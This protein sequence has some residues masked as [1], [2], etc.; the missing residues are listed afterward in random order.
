M[1]KALLFRFL[2]VLCLALAGCAALGLGTPRSRAIPVATKEDPDFGHC[3][4]SGYE[5]DLPPHATVAFVASTCIRPFDAGAS[6]GSST[7][8]SSSSA[9]SDAGAL[10]AVSAEGGAP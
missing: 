3:A 6:S 7:P 10:S 8:A 9:V 2:A 4:S 1:V 5:V